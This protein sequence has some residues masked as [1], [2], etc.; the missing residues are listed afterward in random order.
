LEQLRFGI[1]GVGGIA[2]NIHLPAMAQIPQAKLVA[3]ADVLD[4]RAK[5]AAERF[6]AE[7]FYTDHRALLART[8]VDA[9][10][11]STWHPFHAPIAIEVLEAGKHLLVQKPMATKQEDADRLVGLAQASDRI[12]MALPFSFSPSYLKA[13]ALIREGAIGR[14][15][16]ARARI[17]HGGP[18]PI[19][20]ARPGEAEQ[21]NWFYIR[22]KAVG[23]ALFDMGVYAVS[24]ISGLVSPIKSVM[25]RTSTVLREVDVEENAVI[26]AE[27]RNGAIG[28]IETSWDQV[29]SDESIT[30]YGSEGTI[31]LRSQIPTPPS[32]GSLL[33]L[34]S[35]SA[36]FAGAAGWVTVDVPQGEP[37]MVDA[38]RHWVECVLERKRPLATVEQGRHVV[39]VMIGTYKSAE[40]G[41]LVE[42]SSVF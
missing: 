31:I 41:K 30:V 39:E 28:T 35:Q 37:R 25:A 3:V 16:M 24:A 17:A 14:V 7:A 12:S 9:V 19:K 15:V 26:V 22:E 38:H 40:T 4:Y 10:I 29:A 5:A 33:M 6:G 11:V 20:R 23:G 1:I 13:Q 34:Y 32:S 42:I 27:F 2:T 36:S 21:L 8:D 18:G